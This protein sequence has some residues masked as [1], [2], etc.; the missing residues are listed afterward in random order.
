MDEDSILFEIKKML[1]I[2]YEDSDFDLDLI[3]NINSIFSTLYQIGVGDE[4]SYSITS[5]DDEWEAVFSD[6]K[7]LIDHIKLYTYMKTRMIF[8]P[9]TSSTLTEALKGEIAEL[10]WR[11]QVQAEKRDVFE[12]ND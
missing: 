5:Y 7:D 11:I 12:S 4:G 9:P 2:N 1:G 8:D 6:R 10:E 3:V